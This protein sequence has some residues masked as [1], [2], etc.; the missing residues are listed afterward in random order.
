MITLRPD[1]IPAVEALFNSGSGIIK[2]PAGSGKTIVGAE[3]I[4]RWLGGDVNSR[5]LWVAHTI[6]Q[7]EQ[8]KKAAAM[9]EIPEEII[10]FACYQS[11]PK[12]SDYSLVLFDECHHIASP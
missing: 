5:I 6:E 10:D 11:V 9:A 2:A 12:A 7:V 8:G 1:Q 4:R 3:A